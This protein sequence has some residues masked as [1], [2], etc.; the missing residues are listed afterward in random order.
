MQL[1]FYKTYI[2]R[3]LIVDESTLTRKQRAARKKQLG[4][5]RKLKKV[6]F[7]EDQK[8]MDNF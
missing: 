8:D 7:E 4:T 6:K 3:E 2:K 5:L 1:L